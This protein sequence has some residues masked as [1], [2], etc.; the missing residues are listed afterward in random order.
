MMV[1]VMNGVVHVEK[2]YWIFTVA[3]HLLEHHVFLKKRKAHLI[4]FYSA[5]NRTHSY[6]ILFLERSCTMLCQCKVIPRQYVPNIIKR[7][8]TLPS[9]LG[10]IKTLKYLFKD[11]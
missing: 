6:Y 2:R 1:V 9:T 8:F 7:N 4:I 3:N 10:S 5:P 11:P